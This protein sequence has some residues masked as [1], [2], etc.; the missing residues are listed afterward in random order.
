MKASELR[1]G[2]LFQD[3]EGRLCQVEAVYSD[4]NSC[5]IRAINSSITSMPVKEIPLNDE[6]LAR[7]GFKPRGGPGGSLICDKVSISPQGETHLVW[8]HTGTFAMTLIEIEVKAVH[9]LQNLFFAL[10]GKE[11][12][13]K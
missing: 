8:L 12:E 4:I 9:Q 13:V 10:I 11:L 3:R 5:E 6:W 2:N 1:L 7:L